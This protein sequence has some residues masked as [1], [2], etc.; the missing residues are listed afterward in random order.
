MTPPSER[1]AHAAAVIRE[2]RILRCGTACP[3]APESLGG[4]LR[5]Q[6]ARLGGRPMFQEMGSSGW[7]GTSWSEFAARVAGTAGWLEDV[8]VEV[9]DRVVAV[10]GNRGEML[11]A[12]FAAAALGAIHVPIFAGYSADQTRALVEQA[13]PTV[14]LVA[15]PGQLARTGVPGS[16]RAVASF[17]PPRSGRAD[18]VPVSAF[19]EVAVAAPRGTTAV[20]LDRAAGVDPFTPS[21]MLY[22]SGTTGLN[23]GV[24]L[25]HD[26][27]LSQQRALSAGVWR[28][29]PEDRFLSYLPWHHSFGGNFEKFAA[30]ANGALLAIDDSHGRDF[31]RLLANWLA[32]RPTVYFSV[33][34]LFQQLVSHVETHPDDE[35][36]I[37]RSGLR[38]VFTAAA[39]LPG[40]L[41]AFFAARRIPVQE[42]WGLTETSPCCT[43]TDPTE[44]R[45]QAG[46]VGYP[47]PGVTIRLAPDG[48]ILVRGPNV[49]PG[50][51]RNP[52]ATARALPG[53][54]WF[55][56]GD[57]G[58][59]V[60]SAL[61]LVTRK[62]RVFKLL[63]AEKVV[64][65]T[66]E[67]QLAG[68]N[69]YI[70]HIIVAGEGRDTLSALIFPDFF[71]IEQEFG[72]DR[73]HAERTV[74]A[75][76]RETLL[77]FNREHPIKYER[78][79]AFAVV[80]RELSVENQELTPSLKL[81][82]RN[83]LESSRDY[84]EAI[85]QPTVDCDCR[86]LRKVMRLAPDDR[87]CFMG[88][89]RTLDRCHDC[90]GFVFDDAD[91]A[92]AGDLR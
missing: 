82:F 64:P 1:A 4:L 43:V 25:T 16:V 50:Y 91:T 65:T 20:W 54:G 58:E 36:P 10:S 81:R 11:V 22:T 75:S 68:R 92:P 45:D 30:L 88:L 86:F 55:H 51:F 39:P 52:E 19:A 29:T 79:Q 48:E 72:A 76:L 70:R 69:P 41:S 26:N 56:T 17:D 74:K 32:V 67:Q 8:G 78:I 27:L 57:L 2:D 80:S 46:V 87:R 44:E 5:R 89:D 21:L 15:E 9:G 37:F 24:L 47:I 35:V 14:L 40:H 62:D 61:K 84:L 13:A 28:V 77:E 3:G 83:V 60:G 49:M 31:P 66:L 18:G 85:Y 73:E 71:R 53:D 90:A 12:E 34:K 7:R 59:F 33:P 63:N 42:G 38:F 23:K 6:V